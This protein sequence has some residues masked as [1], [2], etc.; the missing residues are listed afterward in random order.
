MNTN[1]GFI[2]YFFSTMNAKHNITLDYINNP[3]KPIKKVQES[4][5]TEMI[6]PIM[7]YKRYSDFLTNPH[8]PV[9]RLIERKA[10]IK[11][12]EKTLYS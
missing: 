11:K 6:K 10:S 3:I 5:Q 4:V 7:L 12:R 9:I 8:T 2:I 1:N